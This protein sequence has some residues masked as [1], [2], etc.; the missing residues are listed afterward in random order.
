MGNFWGGDSPNM[1]NC[2]NLFEKPSKR[3]T[4]DI[5]ERGKIRTIHAHRSKGR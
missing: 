1:G 3:K 2:D 5:W 4:G